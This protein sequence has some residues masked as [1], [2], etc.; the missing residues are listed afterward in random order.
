M[1]DLLAFSLSSP[2][3]SH[4]GRCGYLRCVLYALRQIA[5]PLDALGAGTQ[6]LRDLEVRDSL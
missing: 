3:R 6:S 5:T 1:H 4:S 2:P